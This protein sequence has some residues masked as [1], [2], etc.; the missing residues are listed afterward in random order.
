MFSLRPFSSSR[1][2]RCICKLWLYSKILQ[3]RRK[4]LCLPTLMRFDRRTCKLIF[5]CRC[6]ACWE[7]FAQ[8]CKAWPIGSPTWNP[9]KYKNGKAPISTVKSATPTAAGPTTTRLYVRQS[10][11]I[12]NCTCTLQYHDSAKSHSTADSVKMHRVKT[13][14]AQ[15]QGSRCAH[16]Q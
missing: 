6:L 9:S 15:G 8:T 5:S 4:T 16:A 13:P 3:P 10:I 7:A 1:Y 14:L 12:Y 11:L 2:C